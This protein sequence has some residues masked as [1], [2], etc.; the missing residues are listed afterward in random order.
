MS[1][2]SR[3]MFM[4]LYW[5]THAS[6]CLKGL[7]VKREIQNGGIY[8]IGQKKRH[9]HTVEKK[10][11]LQSRADFLKC[12]VLVISLRYRCGNGEEVETWRT[13]LYPQVMEQHIDKLNQLSK[14]LILLF[15]KVEKIYYFFPILSHERTI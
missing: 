14:N 11:W 10:N 4:L 3:T 15:P 5:S 12:E 1:G 7:W 2:L 9:P 6:G 13:V 8:K